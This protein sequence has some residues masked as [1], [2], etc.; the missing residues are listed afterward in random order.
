MEFT[1][2][3]VVPAALS[4]IL[5]RIFSF[6][7]DTFGRQAPGARD[8]HRRRLEQLLGNIG[9]MVEEAEGRHI[10]NQ[11][12]LAHLKA[13]TVGMYRG[14]FA[15]EVT[16][17]D[18]VRNAGGEGDDD[19]VEGDDATD[20]A[21]AAA[22]KRSFALRTSFNK[23]KR[24]RVT[25]L[26]LGGGGAGDDGAER[27]AAA[28]EDLE[29]L[30][31]D[32]MREFIM[33]V[34][35]Y[36]RKVDRPVR[37]TL[38][39]DRCVFGRHVEKERIVDFL[40]QRPPSGRAPFLSVLAV[41]GAKKVG[42]TTLVKHACDDERVR[43]RFARIE[44]FETPDVVR[45]GGRPD[46]TVWESD[47]PEYLAGVRRI[48][49][50]P[51]FAAGRSLLVF[52]DAW[53]IDESAWSALAASPS[54]LADGSK[55]LLTCRDADLAR[56]GTVEPVVLHT[57]QQ[58]EYWY[59]FKAFAFGGADPREHPRIAAVAREI[60][61]HLESTFLEAR[62]L[63]TLLRANFDAR[64]WRRVLAA[65]VRCERRPMH[66]GVLLEL[67]PVRGRLQSY[68]YC[69]SPPKFTVQD[70]LSARA[71]GGVPE[72][73]FTIHLC[74]ETLYMDHWYSITFKNDGAPPPVLTT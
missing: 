17:L 68:G 55:L 2:E 40:L 66:V 50:E 36:P 23:A 3:V 54:A 21:V 10:T 42:K 59:Y 34:Q 20:A 27:L 73:G 26:I 24:S 49:G 53:P 22:G 13:L 44:W 6:L 69:R 51:R 58:E 9:S 14:R 1:K 37:T 19:G 38:Y 61:E 18:D 8:V 33:L 72:D 4:E 32:Y 41:V 63:G 65:I 11:Q 25:R 56:L 67:L 12:L 35:G 64:F 30:T 62:V 28:V 45:R 46:Q 48:L 31:R 74:R 16:D 5:S 71:G 7:F 70:V 60:S 43:G 47:G 39:M 57:L 52:E 15:L 29:S